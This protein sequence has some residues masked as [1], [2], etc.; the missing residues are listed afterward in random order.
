MRLKKILK[1][2]K[3]FLMKQRNKKDCKTCIKYIDFILGFHQEIGKKYIIV[4]HREKTF[5]IND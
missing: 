3:R 2:I 1:L 4:N 5:S